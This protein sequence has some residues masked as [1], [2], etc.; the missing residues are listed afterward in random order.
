MSF[1]SWK[2]LAQ[3]T[4]AEKGSTPPPPAL[5]DKD[6]QAF[7][8]SDPHVRKC[9]SLVPIPPKKNQ[10]AKLTFLPHPGYHV[11]NWVWLECNSGLDRDNWLARPPVRAGFPSLLLCQWGLKAM[12]PQSDCCSFPDRM[13]SS[14]AHRADLH[15]W[16]GGGQSQ[17][18]GEGLT[19]GTSHDSPPPLP[20]GV[21]Y[22]LYTGPIP[23]ELPQGGR[24]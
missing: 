4:W 6:T 10:E 16:K 24:R 14:E 12:A 18:C 2:H 15:V 23:A 5:R 20:L 9:S 7:C 13:R 17:V 19:V 1:P 8:S 21:R 22:P 3:S 11:E